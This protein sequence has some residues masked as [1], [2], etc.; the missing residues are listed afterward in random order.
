M[1]IKFKRVQNKIGSSKG[2]GKWY[3]KIVQTGVVNTEEIA[4][5]ICHSTSF[6]FS[7]VMGVLIELSEVMRKHL[8]NS[9]KVSLYRIGSFRVG[10]KSVPTK[11][12][13]DCTASCIKSYHI[14][15]S[16]ETSFNAVGANDKGYSTG[17]YT[18]N[19]LKGIKASEIS[20][21]KPT[22]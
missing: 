19:M 16:P 17:F 6:T 20:D 10:I 11:E 15:Y 22:A 1:S 7:D 12:R 9:Q 2:Y 4:N 3:P 18:K 5:E 8:L 13:K 21:T 14:V